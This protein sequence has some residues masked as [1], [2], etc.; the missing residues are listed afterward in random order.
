MQVI[1]RKNLQGNRPIK[2]RGSIDG[3]WECRWS[4]EDERIAFSIGQ[5]RNH[6]LDEWT[7]GPNLLSST[8]YRGNNWN[9]L[10]S[11]PDEG[12]KSLNTGKQPIL[13][14]KPSAL[15][16]VPVPG[17]SRENLFQ[18]TRANA[19]LPEP[20]LVRRQRHD[21]S[22]SKDPKIYCTVR[23]CVICKQIWASM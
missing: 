23:E 17:R 8:H 21:S 14:I 19:L 22:S 6:I 11:W 4:Y 1:A 20:N 10:F 18:L 7:L 15:W 16:T 13:G 2:I 5:K 3:L 12:N 9:T